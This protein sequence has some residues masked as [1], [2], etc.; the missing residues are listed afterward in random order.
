M[1]RS[2]R[3]ICSSKSLDCG[4]FQLNCSGFCAD[5]NGIWQ[6]TIWSKAGTQHPATPW[7]SGIQGQM[8]GRNSLEKKPKKPRLMV[9]SWLLNSRSPLFWKTLSCPLRTSSVF[10]CLGKQRHFSDFYSVYLN[11]SQLG[12]SL[13]KG[14]RTQQSILSKP[15]GI[16][17]TRCF[18]L[19][20]VRLQ[21]WR[22]LQPSEVTWS[23]LDP[24][25]L[26]S[27]VPPRQGARTQ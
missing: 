13:H 10:N 18:T 20:A 3:P 1:R 24:R 25:W 22:P 27:N 6:N 12:T 17:L 7:Q 11:S 21:A 19:S 15:R 26:K 16:V 2:A 14:H 23:D 8:E 9:G 4:R 5:S